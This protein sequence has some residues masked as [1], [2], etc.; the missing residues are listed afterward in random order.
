[1]TADAIIKNRAFT[2]FIVSP[3]GMG[4]YGTGNPYWQQLA[5]SNRTFPRNNTVTSTY[6]YGHP[7]LQVHNTTTFTNFNPAGTL[8]LHRSYGLQN[9][10]QSR[11]LAAGG[12]MRVFPISPFSFGVNPMVIQQFYTQVIRTTNSIT[13]F[14]TYPDAPA[15]ITDIPPPDDP[16]DVDLRDDLIQTPED[17]DPTVVIVPPPSQESDKSTG[18][19]IKDTVKDIT[20]KIV[21]QYNNITA[22]E[23]NVAL[24][25]TSLGIVFGAIV[26][27]SVVAYRNRNRLF[28]L[29]KGKAFD[30]AA[31]LSLNPLYSGVESTRENPLYQSTGSVTEPATS[32]T[33][34]L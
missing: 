18:D 3:G 6:Q 11:V 5:G 12:F 30:K 31:G 13:Q 23:T 16:T 33:K 27:T 32:S 17:P 34:A 1:M 14:C 4:I 25:L 28:A 8:E 7:L 10:L 9:S 22:S 26:L 20:D 15:S 19:K 2:N 21:E 29:F 24:I